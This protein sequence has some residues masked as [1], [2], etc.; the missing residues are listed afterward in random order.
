MF[1]NKLKKSELID[2]LTS[3]F[4]ISDATANNW[5]K[6]GLIDKNITYDQLDNLFNYIENIKLNSRANKTLSSDKIIPFEYLQNKNSFKLA[7]FIISSF[8]LHNID[9][10]DIILN[11]ILYLLKFKGFIEINNNNIV[12]HHIGLK[13]LLSTYQFNLFIYNEALK[14]TFSALELFFIYEDFDPLGSLYQYILYEG[15]KIKLGSYYT[16]PNLVQKIIYKY[17][18]KI[19]KFMDPC[20]GTG[21]F[22][23]NFAKAKKL[24]PQN[25]IGFDIDPYAVLITK[26]NLTLLYPNFNGEFY[27][28]HQDY[29]DLNNI[30]N[31]LKDNQINDIDLIATNPPWRAII[32]NHIRF[33]NDM[34][35]N[36]LFTGFIY[37]SIEILA[38]KK[39]AIFLLP[40]SFLNVKKHKIIRNYLLDN[41]KIISI[42]N[43]GRVF[44]NV[45]TPA[46]II[47][48]KKQAK[49]S[50]QLTIINK[51]TEDIN[52]NFFRKNINKEFNIN[53]TKKD[54]AI[55]DKIYSQKHQTLK[56]KSHWALGIVTGNNSLL[57]DVYKKDYLPI[58]KGTNILPYRMTEPNFYLKFEPE[59]LQQVAKNNLYFSNEKIIYKFI[60]NKLTFAYD[61]KQ[62]LTLNSANILI[63][64]FDNISLKAVL[65]FLNS[66]VFNYLHNILFDTHK[67]LRSNIETLP[68]PILTEDAN[69]H[70]L[71]LVDKIIYNDDY[72][73]DNEINDTIYQ[74]FNLNNQE[75]D[76]INNH[77][78]NI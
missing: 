18:Y 11:S 76:I 3:Y 4:N 70:L 30:A 9:E 48:L 72:H 7:K 60:S 52:I 49:L 15:K 21:S 47:H 39:D 31:I 28:F 40:Y 53:V 62:Y 5:I 20:C 10:N 65:G 41:T 32:K 12:Y 68:F 57:S 69:N 67:I 64:M 73:T 77:P 45:Y 19:T 38:Y 54:I 44:N 42:E 51:S 63:P 33:I 50:Y 22:L 75:I 13:K 14:D 46:I 36:E 74:L 24:E 16:P 66:K 37:N 8:K 71:Y 59:K 25:L 61:N 23:I 29:L 58:Y 34:P 26:I 43:C 55:I 1:K 35:I 6:T 78:I 2:V 17:P 27:I 56:N